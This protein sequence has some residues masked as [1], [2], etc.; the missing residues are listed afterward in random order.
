[1]AMIIP[2]AAAVTAR[3][4]NPVISNNTFNHTYHSSDKTTTTTTTTQ[5][6]AQNNNHSYTS[7]AIEIFV[8]FIGFVIAII[9]TWI[10]ANIVERD[11]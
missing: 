5:N 10:I 3:P 6:Y 9:L 4:A 1:M 7:Y 11:S 8:I 2:P